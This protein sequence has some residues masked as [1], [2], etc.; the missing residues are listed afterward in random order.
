MIPTLFR[1]TFGKVCPPFQVFLNDSDAVPAVP[2]AAFYPIIPAR[3]T[4]HPLMID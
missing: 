2:W 4:R 3:V 1:G